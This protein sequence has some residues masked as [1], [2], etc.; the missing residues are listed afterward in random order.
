MR[1]TL[2]LYPL[3]QILNMII[4]AIEELC[5]RSYATY[6]HFYRA[7]RIQRH[8]NPSYGIDEPPWDLLVKIGADVALM[9]LHLLQQL[10]V[11]I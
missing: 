5:S 10:L 1:V 7:Y 8:L 9:N 2:V 3:G 11:C 4:T 6:Y